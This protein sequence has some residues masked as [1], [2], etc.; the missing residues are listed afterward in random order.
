[1]D[2]GR[3]DI[4]VDGA[5]KLTA[6]PHING[7]IHCNPVI[8]FQEKEAGWH[9]ISVRMAEGD[10]EKTFTILGFGYVS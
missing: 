1:M 6:D 4:F 5:K 2:A 9:R 8:V 10:E 7:W 3:A